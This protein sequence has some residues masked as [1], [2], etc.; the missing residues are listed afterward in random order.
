MGDIRRATTID[1][2]ATTC[3]LRR[4]GSMTI[5]PH[6]FIFSSSFLYFSFFSS[7][8]SDFEMKHVLLVMFSS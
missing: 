1:G 7:S 8:F 6:T 4:L 2:E 5:N 3:N